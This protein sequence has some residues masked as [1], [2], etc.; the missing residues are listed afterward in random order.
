MRVCLCACVC[1]CVRACVCVRPW[2]RVFSGA[3]V[4]LFIMTFL[5][6]V[7]A[8]SLG[9]DILKCIEAHCDAHHP[10]VLSSAGPANPARLFILGFSLQG[11]GPLAETLSVQ[12][13]VP[14]RAVTVSTVFSVSK[15]WESRRFTTLAYNVSKVWESRRFTTLAYNVSKVWESRRFTAL[16]VTVFS[17][18][19]DPWPRLYQFELLFQHER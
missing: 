12:T 5:T 18:D 11:F 16:V 6:S 9:D 3:R 1:V 8:I 10:K 14:A 13:P 4:C 17:K 2:V 7:R 15:V 19:V